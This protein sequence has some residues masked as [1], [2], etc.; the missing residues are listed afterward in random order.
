MR[1]RDRVLHLL[2]LAERQRRRL[3]AK[4]GFPDRRGDH[5]IAVRVGGADDDDRVD[6]GIVDQREGIRVPSRHVEFARRFLRELAFVS[7]TAARLTPVMRAA[8]SRA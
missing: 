5:Q 7:A 8:R 1:A 4:H 3:L 6:R 2:R